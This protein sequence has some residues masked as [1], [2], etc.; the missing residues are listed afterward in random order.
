[1]TENKLTHARGFNVEILDLSLRKINDP[2][3]KVSI[4]GQDKFGSLL[5]SLN[6]TESIISSAITG[7]MII[8]EPLSLVDDFSLNAQEDLVHVEFHTPHIP[9]SNHILEFCVTDARKEGDPTTSDARD[10][11]DLKKGYWKINFMSC[12]SYLYDV[13]DWD[14]NAAFMNNDR[15]LKIATE[16]KEDE[17]E[18]NI[19][20]L[21]NELANKYFNPTEEGEDPWIKSPMEIEETHNSIWLKP[22]PN[23]YPWGKRT[24]SMTLM[25]LM[26]NLSENAI[27]TDLKHCNFLF[28]RDFGGWHFK[29]INKI[30]QDN[31][32]DSENKIPKSSEAIP[33]LTQPYVYSRVDGVTPLNLQ[34]GKGDPKILNFSDK[35]GYDHLSLW[36]N[37]AYSSYYELI[38]PNHSD[39]YHHYMDSSSEYPIKIIDYNY[40]RDSSKWNTVEEYKLIPETIKT[41]ID[42]IEPNKSRELRSDAEIYGYFSPSLNDN[43]PK[44]Y[45]FIASRIS[46]GK[47]GRSNNVMWQTM[48]DQT[49]L[50]ISTLRTIQNQII[51]PAK[52]NYKE[53][54]RLKNLK[55]KWNVYRHTICCDKQEIKTQFLAVIDNAKLIQDNDRGGIYEYSWREVEMWPTDAINGFTGDVGEDGEPVEP[56]ILTKQEAPISIVVVPNGLQGVM[57]DGGENGAF[58]INELLNT[59]DGDNVFVGPGVNVADGE[60][61]DYPEAY[62]MM[63]VGGYFE[64]GQDPCNP[65]DN[66]VRFHKHIVQMNMIPSYV[67]ET[68]VPNSPENVEEGEEIEMPEEIYFFDVPNAHDGLCECLE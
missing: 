3:K 13:A 14:G 1:M 59:A 60:N 2:D 26:S 24:K 12:E 45:D 11:G 63:P 44:N 54:L 7:N 51:K 34:D 50:N 19:S 68:V 22:N 10:A 52:E 28:W 42:P 21:V 4:V 29:S 16:P 65:E 46:D 55:E 38:E 30:I 43:N 27:T 57:G 8:K 37:G 15:F 17:E 18:E 35:S 67:L 53:Y 62:Q 39:P 64:V 5:I 6:I 36:K 32:E 49:N 9:D 41:D 48:N 56:E 31:E 33:E 66:E 47:Y 40:H 23:L 25:Q 20:G 58:N 61:N